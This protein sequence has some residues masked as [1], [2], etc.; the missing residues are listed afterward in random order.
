MNERILLISW[1]FPPARS[2]SGFNLFKRIKDSGFIFDVIYASPQY[3]P[4][5]N[6]NMFNGAKSTFN[7]YQV[8]IDNDENDIIA[9]DGRFVSEAVSLMEKLNSK[10][11]YRHMLSHSNEFAS[12][13]A[14]YEVKNKHPEIMWLA[15][16]G[17]PLGGNPYCKF[18][19]HFSAHL[20]HEKEIYKNFDG[21]IVTNKYQKKIM[22]DYFNDSS[23]EDKFYILPHSF[24]PQFYEERL[25]N[26]EKF[27]FSHI[28]MLYKY[29]RTSEPF[30]KAI[31][32]LLQKYPK[33]E[34]TF[35]V[36]FIGADDQYIKDYLQEHS[37]THVSYIPKV[38]WQQS[39]YLMQEAD[40]LLLR[41]ADFSSDG[42]DYSPFYPGKLADY[43]GAEK[44]V[45]AVTMKNGFVA[46][47]FEN[48]KGFHYT[49]ENNI[50]QL[51]N[52]LKNAIDNKIS[53]ISATPWLTTM[54]SGYNFKT[55]INSVKKKKRI[56]F[57][58]HKLNF[59][60]PFI[61]YLE[62]NDEY[63]VYIDK[64][65]DHN[66]HDEELSRN[67]LNSSDIIF[68]EWGLGNSVWYSRNKKQGQKMIIRAHL[69]EIDLNYL[70]EIN[71]ENIDSFITITPCMYEKFMQKFSIPRHKIRM[72]YNLIPFDDFSFNNNIQRN[73]KIGFIGYV[74]S[75]KRLDMAIDVFDKIWRKDNEFSLHIKGKRPEDY[76]WLQSRQ[77]EK[78]YYDALYGKL[79][80]LPC[81]NNII[82]EQ[83][84]NDVPNFLSRMGYIMST[85]DFEGSHQAIAEGMC[86][87]CIPLIRNW[88]GAE[89]VYPEK[90]IFSNE[91]GMVDFV[92][93]Q[94][95]YQE[96]E[97]LRNYANIHFSVA[98]VAPQLIELFNS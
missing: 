87:G 75:R 80:T 19:P 67:L 4:R 1:H 25:Y 70:N 23:I 53:R 63:D 86:A 74:P 72:I 43:L 94:K 98:N 32:M 44:P 89:T 14:A 8:N 55:I 93:S 64:W 24:D 46:D 42:L 48:N 2:S 83:F 21:I 79:E 56:L 91:D 85:S 5:Q 96:R 10:F 90:F 49:D 62:N 30:L 47:F 73:K 22:L 11:H 31:D 60:E 9:R 59:I 38:S 36:N 29:M 51:V 57:A 3:A 27:I 77:E 15:S 12:H 71:L 66:N 13:L 33:Y 50:N 6:L 65:T 69:Q 58:G 76:K 52:L 84:G 18:Y 92:L 28:G 34:N 40:C 68:C 26:N 41:D 20:E 81:K 82:F 37:N 54:K 88:E 78:D 35:H 45:I 39:L 97:K 7:C 17:D 95:D 61:K 16:Y